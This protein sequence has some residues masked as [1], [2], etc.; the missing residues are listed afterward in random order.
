MRFYEEEREEML[1]NKKG[2]KNFFGADFCKIVR[3][4]VIGVMRVI[5]S[6]YNNKNNCIQE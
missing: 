6:T 1:R 4:K 5:A 2:Q 3:K